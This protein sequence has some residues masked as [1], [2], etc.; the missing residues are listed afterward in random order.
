VPIGRAGLRIEAE[1]GERTVE[2]I[3]DAGGDRG[4]S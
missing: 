2:E 1:V 4:Q 3:F